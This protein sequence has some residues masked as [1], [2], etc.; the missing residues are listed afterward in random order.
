M[1]TGPAA[2]VKITEDATDLV[3]FANSP[4]ICSPVSL[5][6]WD[7]VL[8]ATAAVSGALPIIL[9]YTAY[10][11]AIRNAGNI[12]VSTAGLAAGTTYQVVGLINPAPSVSIDVG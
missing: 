10:T 7:T 11:Q 2:P 4:N 3:V 12:F 8:T 9:T 1:T 5:Q 6:N